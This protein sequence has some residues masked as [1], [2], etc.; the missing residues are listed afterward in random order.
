VQVDRYWEPGEEDPAFRYNSYLSRFHWRHLDLMDVLS[1]YQIRG[2][3]SLSSIALLLGLP[4]KLGFSGAQVWDAFRAGNIEGVRRY[5][6]TDVLNTYLIFL[7]FER[8]RGRL[9]PQG[10]DAECARVREL[11]AASAEPHHLEFLAAWPA[12]ARG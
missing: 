9:T 12:P 3:A 11:L 8:M 1:G 5:C 10:H 6:E 2:R 4:G 7:A